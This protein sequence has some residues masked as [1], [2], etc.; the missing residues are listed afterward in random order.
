M[1]TCKEWPAR[2]VLKAQETFS[3]ENVQQKA[4]RALVWQGFTLNG[5]KNGTTR[6]FH[7]WIRFGNISFPTIIFFGGLVFR[8]AG[9]L[10]F[11]GAL[12]SAFCILVSRR[13]AIF[14]WFAGCS[15][16]ASNSSVCR[17]ASLCARRRLPFPAIVELAAQTVLIQ[18]W[19]QS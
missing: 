8:A 1:A 2:G 11:G 14:S 18:V 7:F 13:G 5:H 9:S 4:R 12:Q 10:Y 15:A 3:L 16:V 19:Q 17:C 6:R